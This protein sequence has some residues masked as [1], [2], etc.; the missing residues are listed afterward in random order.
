MDLLEATTDYFLV[1]VL[2]P[3][4]YIALTGNAYLYSKG[5]VPKTRN[6]VDRLCAGR[7]KVYSS[8]RRMLLELRC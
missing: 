1:L 5:Q 4:A 6:G 7:P 8:S 2:L 3:R